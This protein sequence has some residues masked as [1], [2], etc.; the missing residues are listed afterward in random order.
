MTNAEKMKSFLKET[1]EVWCDDC[2]SIKTGI[3]PRQQ[4]YQL[5]SRLA[6]E[7]LVWWKNK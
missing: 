4:V 2:L 6:R 1:G 5:G 3:S 7:G